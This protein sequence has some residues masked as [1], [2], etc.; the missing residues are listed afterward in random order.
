MLPKG[1]KFFIILFLAYSCTYPVQAGFF[2]PKKYDASF[3][4]RVEKH[5]A[6]A[7][8]E[9]VLKE[10]S[11]LDKAR[12]GEDKALVKPLRGDV[13]YYHYK[14]SALLNSDK[15]VTLFDLLALYGRVRSL[16]TAHYYLAQPQYKIAR[17]KLLSGTDKVLER[18]GVLAARRFVNAM[19]SWGD[20]TATYRL[21]YPKKT[22]LNIVRKDVL[23]T[24]LREYD[25][26]EIDRKA[27]ATPKQRSIADQAFVLTKDYQYDFEKV[28]AI[29]VWI[30]HNIVYDY[31]Y[32]IYDAANTFRRNTGV[33]SGY[34]YLFKE[35]CEYA[36]LK[37]YRI[38]GMTKNSTLGHAW[39][40]A[41]V[42]GHEF[43][44]DATWAAGVRD[45]EY[46]YLISEKELSKTHRAEKKE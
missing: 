11:E 31:S 20:T 42:H 16:D 46:Y 25:Y 24:Y 39:N 38:T 12:F 8:Y 26:S 33:C 29:Y 1:C 14:L 18:S 13:R 21:V 36:G 27:K 7:N 41:M 10:L 34:S 23:W 30:I 5:Y 45:K 2:K 9:R 6:K 17:E 40:T 3:Y 44:V 28:R 4:E 22:D 32:S 19:A 35:M 15:P 37:S 43:L